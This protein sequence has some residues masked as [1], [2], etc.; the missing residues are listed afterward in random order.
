M[1]YKYFGVQMEKI[2][3]NRYLSKYVE[4][5]TNKFYEQENMKEELSPE[6][7]ITKNSEL[8]ESV[9]RVFRKYG[10]Q[11]NV[12]TSKQDTFS[13]FRDEAGFLWRVSTSASEQTN[14]ES[15]EF[16]KESVYGDIAI[17][18][19]SA[20][21]SEQLK[22]VLIKANQFLDTNDRSTP[23]KHF[24]F[25]DVDGVL[26]I[27]S[28]SYTTS[29]FRDGLLEPHLVSRLNYLCEKTSVSACDNASV[30]EIVISSSWRRDMEALKDEL[31]KAGFQH[32]DK[33][34]GATTTN[35][36]I[37]SRGAQI[38]DW[39]K[40]QYGSPILGIEF[41]LSIVDDDVHDIA[42]SYPEQYVHEVNPSIGITDEIVNKIIYK[43]TRVANFV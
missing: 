40:K 21:T 29:K 43:S 13:Y 17:D 30:L 42:D 18:I 41:D 37:T 14:A 6:K 10:S 34:V 31:K 27:I 12:F 35:S 36:N 5:P 16:S 24:L 1:G 26:N 22:D 38:W 32:F 15:M 33:I 20:L 7:I 8:I 19:R 3:R 2:K 4:L 11:I 23:K 9:L 25:L 39:L 28:N